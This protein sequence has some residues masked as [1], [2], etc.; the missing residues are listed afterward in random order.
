MCEAGEVTTWH[1]K[2]SSWRCAPC[3]WSRVR[4]P[5]RPLGSLPE[6]AAALGRPQA[7]N[8]RLLSSRQGCKVQRRPPA[9]RSSPSAPAVRH[10]LKPATTPVPTL[11][12]TAATRWQSMLAA[13]AGAGAGA[14]AGAGATAGAG[15]SS[16]SAVR[17]ALSGRVE[18]GWR[19]KAE[20]NV[21][22]AM[23]CSQP[24]C[25]AWAASLTLSPILHPCFLP[26]LAA[27]PIPCA[28]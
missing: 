9:R 13:P 12:G 4:S 6:V 15:A 28:G 26:P 21:P 2:P 19:L 18:R 20:G 7:A 1:G 27:P 17:A 25:T 10:H 5:P 14:K 22:S 8:A 11:A 24:S 16:A 23:P 3:S